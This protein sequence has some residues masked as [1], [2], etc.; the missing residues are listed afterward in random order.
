MNE[1]KTCP[2]CG[3]IIKPKK[4]SRFS[5]NYDFILDLEMALVFEMWCKGKSKKYKNQI[6]VE[7]GFKKLLKLSNA[8]PAIAT[9]IVE[10]SLAANWEGLFPVKN[11]VEVKPVQE[12][13]N[14]SSFQKMQ[15][16]YGR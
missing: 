11:K 9:E 16:K 1:S 4:S 8:N 7:A 3:Q 6:Q 14:R 5:P 15:E 10:N 2:H 12:V 13:D